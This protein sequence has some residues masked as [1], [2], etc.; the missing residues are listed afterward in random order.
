MFMAQ[1]SREASFFQA[2]ETLYVIVHQESL[3][4]SSQFFLRLYILNLPTWWVTFILVSTPV[5]PGFRA[6]VL[7]WG[8]FPHPPWDIKQSLETFLIVV[9]GG[10]EG[11]GA[12]GVYWAEARMLLHILRSTGRPLRQ[13]IIQPK[14]SIMLLWRIPVQEGWRRKQ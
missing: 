9:I 8:L 14:M 4:L 3:M 10:R 7:N 1:C 6:V 5:T 12:T 11:G 2:T 13:I